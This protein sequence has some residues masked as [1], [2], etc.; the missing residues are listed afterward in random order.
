VKRKSYLSKPA[1][2]I[3]PCYNEAVSIADT[4]HDIN[5]SI[6]NCEIWVI[7]N[8]STDNTA[9]IALSLGA[10]VIY[11]PRQ[12]KGFALRR[13][14]TIFNPDSFRVVFMTDGDHTY[15]IEPYIEAEK[16]IL[17]NS[18]DLVVGRRV[19]AANFEKSK[20][21]TSVYRLGHASGNRMISSFFKYLFKMEI[22]DTLSGWRVMNVG[23]FA[24]FTGGV[25]GF[26]IES[27]LNVHAYRLSANIT[28]VDVPYIGR[29]MGSES[30]L[31]TYKDGLK[32]LFR[33]IFLFQAER[34]FVAYGLI[35]LFPLSASSILLRNV[36]A[37]YFTLHKVP[38]FP[39]LI[40]SIGG[41]LISL[42]LIVT[43]VI[44]Q[45][46]RLARVEET[47]RTFVSASR[48]LN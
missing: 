6:E 42:L 13:A 1:L 12:G 16:L 33:L 7:D 36:L 10:K 26:Q 43:G 31:S 47:R 27:E 5:K 29:K 19:P 8:R 20:T 40:A 32:I 3:L 9:A 25:S 34:P 45:N 44:L 22:P 4:I 23:F 18:F 35:S 46:V 30:K 41:F 2:I 21:R 37:T 48:K 14:I 11:E 15:S 38:K 28:T 24:S 17:L 39:S